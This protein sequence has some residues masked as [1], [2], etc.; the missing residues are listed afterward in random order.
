MAPDGINPEEWKFEL[1]PTLGSTT[2]QR[3]SEL[4][5]AR[6][7]AVRNLAYMNKF[8]KKPDGQP[9]LTYQETLDDHAK[10]RGI[11][12]DYEVSKGWVVPGNGAVMS[13]QIPTSVIPT[14]G[15]VMQPIPFQP[16]FPQFATPAQAA[17][18][19]VNAPPAQVAPM[20][21]P[22]APADIQAPP[23]VGRKRR[24]AGAGVAAPPTAAPP[25]N[26]APPP[27]T[28]VAAPAQMTSTGTVSPPQFAPVQQSLTAPPVTMQFVPQQ[29]TPPPVQQVQPVAIP[30]V[31]AAV[32]L[33]PVL[34]KLDDLGKGLTISAGNSDQAL[35]E[36]TTLRNEVKTLVSS[37]LQI[38]TALH[39][40]YLTIQGANGQ[41]L[42]AGN[43]QGKANDLASFQT[44]LSQFLPK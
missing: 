10:V 23:I 27:Q 26:Y 13:Q 3:L 36:V 35:K 31:P 25:Q 37:Q 11:I 9:L 42:L 19:P 39:H 24:T 30:S 21:P 28:Q 15:A 12:V 14:N 29:F 43:T 8:Y 41:P 6:F 20:A 4:E 38:L 44:Y 17:Q 7:V 32:D 33:T 16:Q 22:P 18:V 2:G 34:Q 1:A 40:V 5:V